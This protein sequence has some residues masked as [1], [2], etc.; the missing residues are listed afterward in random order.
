ME[1]MINQDLRQYNIN[2][3]VRK[4]DKKKVMVNMY[5]ALFKYTQ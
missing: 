5:N 3:N 1:S 4:C 2:R